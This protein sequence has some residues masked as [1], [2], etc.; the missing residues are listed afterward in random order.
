[1]KVKANRC[2]FRSYM[3][4]DDFVHWLMTIAN[5]SNRANETYNVGSSQSALLHDLAI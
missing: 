4:A 1:M 2:V 5:S 3:Y